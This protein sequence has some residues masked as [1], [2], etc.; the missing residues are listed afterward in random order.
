VTLSVG[1]SFLIA[2]VAVVCVGAFIGIVMWASRRPYFKHRT[3][4]QNPTGVTGG[5]HVGDARS[6][7]PHRDEVVEPAEPADAG[8]SGPGSRG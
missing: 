8:H 3:P 6:M 5:I 1:A 7:A 2:L 4:T